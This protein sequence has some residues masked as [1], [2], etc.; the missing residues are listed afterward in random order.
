MRVE[1][2]TGPAFADGQPWQGHNAYATSF[3]ELGTYQGFQGATGIISVPRD[4]GWY[5]GNFAGQDPH[6]P[7]SIGAGEVGWDPPPDFTRIQFSAEDAGPVPDVG[8]M[9]DAGRAAER[10]AIR[11]R[12]PRVS[13][14]RQWPQALSTVFAALAALTVATVSVLGWVLSYNPLQDLASLRVSRNLAELWP[15]VVYGP[16]LVAS[17]SILRA[18]LTRHRA[19]YSWVVVVLFSAVATG[20]CVIHASRTFPGVVVAALPPLTAVVSFHQLVRQIILP[21]RA[22]PAASGREPT[23]RARG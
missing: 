23:H 20:L 18:T 6:C 8:Q 1:V 10:R 19:T 13:R 11:R 14:M 22:R 12:R 7:E 17:L 21:P 5:Y 4:P 9:P 2:S 15:L 16:W 3:Y